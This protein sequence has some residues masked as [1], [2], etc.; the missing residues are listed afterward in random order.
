MSH[1]CGFGAVVIEKVLAVLVSETP[2]AAGVAARDE[3]I[4][5]LDARFPGW[6]RPTTWTRGWRS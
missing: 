2:A 5:L 4:G 6:V 1:C 3:I